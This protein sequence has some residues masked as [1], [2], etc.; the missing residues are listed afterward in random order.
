MWLQ[1]P[2]HSPVSAVCPWREIQ[3]DWG[4]SSP[5]QLCLYDSERASTASR[6]HH[7]KI[8]TWPASQEVFLFSLSCKHLQQLP[9]VCS[10]E[11][12]LNRPVGFI[13]SPLPSGEQQTDNLL[14]IIARPKDEVHLLCATNNVLWELGAE[15]NRWWYA[16]YFTGLILDFTILKYGK[17]LC[18]LDK[19]GLQKGAC[20]VLNLEQG[21][22]MNTSNFRDLRS[23]VLILGVEH[24]NIAQYY[25]S[26]LDSFRQAFRHYRICNF[27]VHKNMQYFLWCMLEQIEW[28]LDLSNRY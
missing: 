11:P 14:N 24:H 8:Q 9:E 17:N 6:S 2:P 19:E 4:C 26:A 10:D 12:D 1:L 7:G 21:P 25:I 5:F 15:S 23:V 27:L 22:F 28:I 18:P 20:T 3:T 16:A 13:I